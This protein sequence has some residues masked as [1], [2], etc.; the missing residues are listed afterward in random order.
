M[1]PKLLSRLA[2]LGLCWALSYSTKSFADAWNVLPSPVTQK[3]THFVSAAGFNSPLLLAVSEGDLFSSQDGG[4][5]WE[6]SLRMRGQNAK[7]NRVVVSEN[8]PNTWYALS[9][10][11]L[12]QSSDTGKNWRKIYDGI[13]SK[14]RNILSLAENTF[15]KGLL[16]LGTADGILISKNNG[17][18]WVRAFSELSKK[19]IL[20]IALDYKNQEIYFATKDK[21]YRYHFIHDTFREVFV[22]SL[23]ITESEEPDD[24]EM[25][26]QLEEFSSHAR[27]KILLTNHPSFTIAFGTRNG[28]F[29]TDDEGETWRRLTTEGLRT[30][31]ILDLVYSEKIKALFAATPKGI[32]KYDLDEKRWVELY[33]GLPSIQ[34]ESL[35]IQRTTNEKLI[36]ATKKGIFYYEIEFPALNSEKVASA[37]FRKEALTQL[38]SLEPSVREVQKEAIRYANVHNGKTA[39]WHAGS[40]LRAF[41]PRLTFSKGLDIG[42]DIHVDTGSTS[43]PDIFVQGPDERSKSTDIGLTWELGDVLFSSAQTS[44]DSRE[45]LMVELRDEIL[46]EVTRLYFERRRAQLELIAHPPTDSL[47]QI[48]ALMRIDELTANL[49]ALTDGYLTKQISKK[50]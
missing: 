19:T 17:K 26:N 1:K 3:S 14:N 2:M 4:K 18:D 11:G 44:I 10:E 29:V 35:A 31:E 9:T 24:E 37:N 34:I 36:A 20:D 6:R 16:Y 40:R 46:A 33:E 21:I 12:F 50:R 48:K 27:S 32:F 45:K 8:N 15:E 43:I 25:E 13:G 49:D 23:F 22:E 30:K 41:I 38:V 5:S 42:N 39:R 28:A 7:I 47:E